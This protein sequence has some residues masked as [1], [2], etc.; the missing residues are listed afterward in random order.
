MQADQKEHGLRAP[1]SASPLRRRG[2]RPDALH[3]RGRL[4]QNLPWD[5]IRTN[6]VRFRTA[7]PSTSRHEAVIPYQPPTCTIPFLDKQRATSRLLKQSFS[8]K[9]HAA[10]SRIAK[11]VSEQHAFLNSLPPHLGAVRTWHSSASFFLSNTC[12]MLLQRKP[13]E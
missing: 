12:A 13:S 2:G 7:T 4:G 5:A 8:V 10:F 9:R 11:V 6:A 3:R 1:S